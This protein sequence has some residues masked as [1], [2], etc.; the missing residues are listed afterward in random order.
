MRS[1]ALA[2][3]VHSHLSTKRRQTQAQAERALCKGK[4]WAARQ[5]SPASHAAALAWDDLDG[6]CAAGR[7]P[8]SE[9][10]TQSQRGPEEPTPSQLHA[11][12]F[13]VGK[14]YRMTAN[15]HIERSGH[16]QRRD[17]KRQARRAV[18][19]AAR[20]AKH[21]SD[22]GG[23][24]MAVADQ[25]EAA[26]LRAEAGSDVAQ[27]LAMDPHDGRAVS[28]LQHRD[29]KRKS[30]SLGD[31]DDQ[32]LN[33]D[34]RLKKV[35]KDKKRKDREHRSA[36]SH[37]DAGDMPIDGRECAARRA[38]DPACLDT[39]LTHL[40]PQDEASS[41]KANQDVPEGLGARDN[42]E[43][44]R[45]PKKRRKGRNDEDTA[46]KGGDTDRLARERQQRDAEEA[47]S[48]A[49][50]SS[51][52]KTGTCA[53]RIVS[54]NLDAQ[55]H[56]IGRKE[57]REV[58]VERLPASEGPEG[59]KARQIRTSVAPKDDCGSVPHAAGVSAS[60]DTKRRKEQRRKRKRMEAAAAAEQRDRD[61]HNSGRGQVDT[62]CG[63]GGNGRATPQASAAATSGASEAHRESSDANKIENTLQ[64]ALDEAL[65][66]AGIPVG[67]GKG[68]GQ[69]RGLGRGMNRHSKAQYP[70]GNYDSY[71]SYR[72]VP[73]SLGSRGPI[74]VR[75]RA[76]RQ[77][78]FTGKDVCDIGCNAGLVSASVA[79]VYSV[80]SMVG[81]DIDATLVSKAR[82]LLARQGTVVSEGPRA[83]TTAASDGS[84]TTQSSAAR[85][86]PAS[87]LAPQPP[88]STPVPAVSTPVPAAPP[89]APSTNAPEPGGDRMLSN[90][91]FRRMFL[92]VSTKPVASEAQ[93]AP[94]VADGASASFPISFAV[95]L[96]GARE[97]PTP[98][99][100][101]AAFPRCVAFHH[102]NIVQEPP[103]KGT[104]GTPGAIAIYLSLIH[105]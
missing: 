87:T 22:R 54:G 72:L 17:A 41:Q 59:E 105:I 85:E 18:K 21:S 82:A 53:R 29:D 1:E 58:Q 8:H 38:K 28:V 69:G 35:R 7:L 37:I 4:T 3:A 44:S 49:N 98:F 43:I 57:I 50:D 71:Y 73:S 11:A 12:G 34:K 74:D 42:T 62:G 26:P 5:A 33:D 27:R 97:E 101:G 40:Y 6:A 67:R 30:D 92:G 95:S 64:P 63:D 13:A 79:R 94:N 23:C 2:A 91:D 60:R 78:W 47:K 86:P 51:S 56:N 15:G 103:S 19:E 80:R 100:P 76:F 89:A 55:H 16:A 81:F 93:T 88:A 48:V 14:V 45:A 25:A 75:L 31:D 102:C 61:G 52:T 68:T 83:S 39:A 9:K 84:A 90:S 99:E 96:G 77:E 10:Q 70:Y 66:V 20:A 36:I 32:I 104:P 46:D 65:A 24:S